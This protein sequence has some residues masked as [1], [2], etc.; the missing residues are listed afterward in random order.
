MGNVESLRKT[1]PR[2]EF[3]YQVLLDALQNYAQP[4][5][6]IND[7]LTK[8]VIVRVKKGLYVF[9]DDY[10]NKPYSRE[11]LANLIYGPSCVSLEYALHHYGLI[12]ERV[13][14]VTSVTT[15]RPKEFQTPVGLFQ[16]RNV[17]EAGFHVGLQRVELNDGRAYLMASPEKALADKF[18]ND[19]GLHIRTR[20]ACLNYLESS[21]RIEPGDL[22][23][24]DV[25][26]LDKIATAYESKRI[27]L[28]VDLVKYLQKGTG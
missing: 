4:R 22:A 26:L 8:G 1:I 5:K 18:R 2:E 17:P 15:K 6:K 19:R 10:R 9:G 14:A 25:A 24:L 21:L 20:K 23:T 28:L 12:P 7:L 11:I 16:Y 3:D 27:H 13:E